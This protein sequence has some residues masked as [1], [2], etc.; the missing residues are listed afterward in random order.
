MAVACVSW[1]A[2]IFLPIPELGK[3]VTASPAA[4]AL[5]AALYQ[6]LRDESK[7]IKEQRLKEEERLH[8]LS[9]SSH[10]AIVAFDKHAEFS[11]KYL[12]VMRKGLNELWAKGPCKEAL[13][14]A[15]K[16]KEK[17]LDYA[18]WVTVDT[19]EALFPF[20]EALTM[21]GINKVLLSDMPVGSERSAMVAQAHALFGQV[22]EFNKGT[23]EKE[24]GVSKVI[25]RIQDL[26]GINELTK[27]RRQVIK[28]ANKALESMA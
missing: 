8:A 17:R 12:E 21:I 28:G 16:L 22:M 15:E 18:A 27:L 4:V 11:E 5:I 9:V 10:M 24:I 19:R 26:L 2:A 3:I 6:I 1:S 20:E 14:L 13:D 25:E 7:F 23:Q